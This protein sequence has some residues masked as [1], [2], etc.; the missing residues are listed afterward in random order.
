MINYKCEACGEELEA[1]NSLSG[2]PAECHKCHN[3]QNVPLPEFLPRVACPNCEHEL[4]D[5]T[6]DQ[7]GLIVKC[8]KCGCAV[9]VPE[10]GGGSGCGLSVLVGVLLGVGLTAL[11]FGLVR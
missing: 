11:T 3:I 10:K 8:P 9:R 2:K 5:L 6:D 4:D 7:A 1:P